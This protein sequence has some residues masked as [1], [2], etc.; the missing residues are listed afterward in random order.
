MKQACYFTFLLPLLLGLPAEAQRLSVQESAQAGE[1]AT[2][3]GR[4]VEVKKYSFVV[5]ASDGAHT[6]KLDKGVRLELRL[7]KPQYQ[8]G[9]NK[10]LVLLPGTENSPNRTEFTLPDT[11]FLK[12]Q[13]THQH[14]MKRIMSANPKRLNNYQLSPF[15]FP[16]AAQEPVI[17]GQLIV[18][19]DQSSYL[20]QTPDAAQHEIVLGHQNASMGGFSIQDLKP[21]TT[22]I[23]VEGVKDGDGFLATRAMFWPVERN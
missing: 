20:L 7:H 22:R 2:L 6:V 14:Q 8:P 11:L 10:L 13:F 5:A 15:P 21:L 19:E 1:Q 4:V 18:D 9:A 16:P 12:V 17:T 3:Q 23:K